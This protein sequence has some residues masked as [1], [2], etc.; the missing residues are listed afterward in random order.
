L[1][2]SRLAS[3]AKESPSS[4]VSV[5]RQVDIAGRDIDRGGP[6]VSW[7]QQIRSSV[8]AKPVVF[9]ARSDHEIDKFSAYLPHQRNLEWCDG[10]TCRFPGAR[11]SRNRQMFGVFGLP[12]KIRGGATAKIVV[13][14]EQ[15]DHEIDKISVYGLSVM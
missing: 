6:T 8:T 15:N 11:G 10:K 4:K 2:L 1:P 3:G 12:V 9:R 7:R 5:H 13:F 14:Q